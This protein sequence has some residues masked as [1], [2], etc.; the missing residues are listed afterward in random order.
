MTNQQLVMTQQ[1]LPP[2][3]T[4]FSRIMFG[5]KPVFQIVFL[6]VKPDTFN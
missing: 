3:D 6:V 1:Q 4:T 2:I 5:S